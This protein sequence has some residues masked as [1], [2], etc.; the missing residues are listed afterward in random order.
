MIEFCGYINEA[1]TLIPSELKRYPERLQT[2]LGNIKA[3]KKFELVDGGSVKIK[4]TPELSAALKSGKLEGIQLV[5]LSGKPIAWGTLKKTAEFDGK[6][7]D[8]GTSHE[9][10]ALLSLNRQLRKIGDVV[11]IK[12]G[13]KT[14][15]VT[16]AK[17]TKNTPKSDFELLDNRGN[18]VIWISHKN[19]SGPRDFNQWGGVTRP[20]IADHK[21]VKK[22]ISDMQRKYGKKIPNK[23]NAR[24]KIK[25]RKLKMMSVFGVDFGNELGPNNI[26]AMIQGEIK[27][28][29]KGSHYEFE[30]NTIFQNGD[31][32]G[33]DYEPVLMIMY[34]GDRDNGGIQGA[35][36]AIYPLYGRGESA[37]WV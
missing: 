24:R 14:F 18:A 31:K 26:S 15:K 30:A 20:E 23:T 2:F 5:D 35:R 33:G 12:I 28:V 25:D 19:G 34:R 36:L 6:N 13:G 11:P 37:E 16:R 3:G 22:F 7:G 29:K 4:L 32:I 8:N 21:E 1:T 27:L 10:A 17:N 9:I